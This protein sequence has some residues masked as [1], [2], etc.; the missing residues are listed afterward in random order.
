MTCLYTAK[1]TLT[2]QYRQSWHINT[3][4]WHVNTDT[5]MTHQFRQ[6]WHWQDVSSVKNQCKTKVTWI[7]WQYQPG[8]NCQ[9]CKWHMNQTRHTLGASDH[10]GSSWVSPRLRH[11]YIV[12]N[13]PVII[14]LRRE[15][16]R[17]LCRTTLLPV[18][19]VLVDTRMLT[20]KPVYKH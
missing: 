11:K 1:Y 6:S 10:S 2:H 18:T 12:T 5:V 8:R 20:V 14:G 9:D 3:E 4:S 15:C 17:T 13:I 19:H 7:H 16:F